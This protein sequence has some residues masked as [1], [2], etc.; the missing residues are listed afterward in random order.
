M[1]D[2]YADPE[3]VIDVFGRK[4]LVVRIDATP[5]KNEVFDA[6]TDRLGLAEPR[7]DS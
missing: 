1:A 4:E 6:V 5:S 7:S 2:F 3:P